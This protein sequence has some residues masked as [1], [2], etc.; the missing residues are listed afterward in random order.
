MNRRLFNILVASIFW[1]T[2][3]AQATDY[4]LKDI[5]CPTYPTVGLKLPNKIGSDPAFGMGSTNPTSFHATSSGISRSGQRISCGYGVRIMSA[6]Y[7]A[8]YSYTVK[9]TIIEC[10][11]LNSITL[12]CKLK[13]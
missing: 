10:Q 5:S 7:P 8:T 4:V 12:R 13:P 11:Q 6:Y 2:S 1:T 3:S 9:R